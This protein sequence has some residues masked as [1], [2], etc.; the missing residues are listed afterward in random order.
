MSSTSQ[1]THWLSDKIGAGENDGTVLGRDGMLGA[2]EKVGSLLDD[3]E[4]ATD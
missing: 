4:G 2:D 1:G 3:N